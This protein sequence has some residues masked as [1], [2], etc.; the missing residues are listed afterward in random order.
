MIGTADQH[1]YV[2][3]IEVKKGT[4]SGERAPTEG[5]GHQQRGEGTYIGVFTH[6][7]CHTQPFAWGWKKPHFLK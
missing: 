7:I 4:N 6:D 2:S 3:E 1:P 5:E